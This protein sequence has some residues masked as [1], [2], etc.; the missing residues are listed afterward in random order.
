MRLSLKLF[1]SFSD[2]YLLSAVAQDLFR[3]SLMFVPCYNQF[4]RLWYPVKRRYFYVFQVNGQ[5][6]KPDQRP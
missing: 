4:Y 2:I 3:L 1:Y 5:Q 6:I